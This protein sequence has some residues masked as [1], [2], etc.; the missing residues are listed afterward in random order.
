MGYLLSF[1]KWFDKFVQEVIYVEK[2]LVDE[3]YGFQGHLDLYASLNR[4]G[5]TLI[6]IKTPTTLYKQWKV[7]LS[8]Y[9]RLLQV[10]K[11][12]ADVVASLQLDPNG[13]IPKMIR[14]EHSY[15]EDFNIF[16]GLR[17]AWYYFK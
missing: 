4:L 12:R 15:A 8:A 16:L 6:D 2:H 5:M 17:N 11:K 1:Q 14:Y 9:Y 10:D 7:Q 13:D 3:A